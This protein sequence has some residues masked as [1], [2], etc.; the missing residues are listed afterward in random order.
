MSQGSETGSMRGMWMALAGYTVLFVAKMVAWKLTGV[1][2]LFAEGMH[3]IA[4]MLI[5]G[6]LLVAAYISRRPADSTYRF[7]YQR[8]QN[9][10]ALTAATVFIA[11]TSFETIREALPKLFIRETGEYGDLTIAFAVLIVSIVISALPLF[12]LLR[13]KQ[14]GAAAKAQL[15]E[16]INDLIA[17]GAALLGTLMVFEGFPIADPIASIVVGV[18]IAINATILWRE[19]ASELMGRSPEPAFFDRVRDTA[20]GIPGVLGVHQMIG[21]VVG[22][23]TRMS[24]HIT[25]PAADSVGQADATAHAVRE[26]VLAWTPDTFL[27]VHMDPEGAPVGE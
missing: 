23:A 16:T 11:F 18:I 20:L 17:L 6:F 14:K 27:V 13:N 2:V 26:A 9:V 8:A 4:D 10:A 1:G 25:V 7:G 3:S 15:I 22:G 5:S 12:S 21:E 24:M 19:N